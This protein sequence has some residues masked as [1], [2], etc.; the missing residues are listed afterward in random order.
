[1]VGNVKK[2][3]FFKL[4]NAFYI[5]DKNFIKFQCQVNFLKVFKVRNLQTVSMYKK[6]SDSKKTWLHFKK[7]GCAR[8]TIK[9][10]I[11]KYGES[12][13]VTFKKK[14]GRNPTVATPRKLKSIENFF[15]KN[16]TT[17]VSTAAKKMKMNKNYLQNIKLHKLG[18]KS[19]TR[20]SAAKHTA[21]QEKT[22]TERLPK[23]HN[24]LLR[25][26]VV[27][28]DESYVRQD[29]LETPGRQFYHA[30]D[31]SKAKTE[32][33][34]KCA[35]K[36]PTKFL[37]WQAL[38]QF[39]NVSEPYVH[40]GCMNSETYLKECVL[41]R[42][43]PFIKKYH[44]IENV[45]FWPDLATIHYANI[46]KSEIEK[47]L[48]LVLTDENPPNVPHLR[49]IERFWAIC[50][51]KYSKLKETP[52]TLRKFRFQ[53]KKISSEVALSSGKALMKDVKRKIK[54]EMDNGLKSSLFA[55]I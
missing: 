11:K 9:R 26:I 47:N 18:I 37:V 34:V 13:N 33:K 44:K 8:T 49:P 19:Y 54:Y 6:P 5:I 20:K 53:W 27:L 32:H 48:S 39:G 22:A 38:D 21:A 12:E 7:E 55:K 14:P 24:K 36:F 15:E 43:I 23:L 2:N 1:M 42:L 51:Q 50:K 30:K 29:P 28:D 4:S 16:P 35:S 3:F 46:V 25:K 45:I 52:D 10:Y 31:P 17:S 41:A 40:E